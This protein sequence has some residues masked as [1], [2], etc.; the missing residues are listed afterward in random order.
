MYY[1]NLSMF[2]SFATLY[3]DMQVLLYGI[4][5]LKVKWLAWLDAI[6]FTYDIFGYLTGHTPLRAL[7]PVIAILNY[8]IFF[9]E[10]L[11]SVLGRGSERI[12]YKMC[13]RDS[14]I[15]PPRSPSIGSPARCLN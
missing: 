4:I 14:G 11:M 13:I 8:L 2:F 3:P 5:P 10:D 1:V 7:L 15:S 12:R 9:W 6:F